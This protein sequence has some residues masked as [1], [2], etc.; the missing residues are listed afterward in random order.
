MNAPTQAAAE[1]ALAIKPAPV[2][3]EEMNTWHKLVSE[4]ERVKNAELALRNKIFAH[5]FQQ[6]KEG[7]NTAPLAAG[8]VIKGDYK[9]NRKVELPQLNVFVAPLREKGIPMDDLIRYKPEV[10]TAEYRKLT[11]EQRKEF[12]QVLTITVGTPSLEVVLP[13]RAAVAIPK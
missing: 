7:T 6:P 12:D 3:Q 13:K 2:T 4:L 10:V 11:D 9:I 1:Q 5:F 8:W